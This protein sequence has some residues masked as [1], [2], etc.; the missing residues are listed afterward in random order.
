MWYIF[1]VPSLEGSGEGDSARSF[2]RRATDP[3]GATY[4][5]QA[6][7]MGGGA[8]VMFLGDRDGQP[9][10]GRFWDPVNRTLNRLIRNPGPKSGGVLLFVLREDDDSDPVLSLVMPNMPEARHK[11]ETI[12]A[13]ITSGR[14][15]P[16]A[17]T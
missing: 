8:S 13:D 3:G 6:S 5:I 1:E 15:D 11:V 17:H 2:V 10:R 12:A 7:V 16:A 14:F 9:L 4:L